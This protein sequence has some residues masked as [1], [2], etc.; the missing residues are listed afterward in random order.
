LVI[1]V[2]PTPELYAYLN[3]INVSIGHMHVYHKHDVIAAISVFR[4]LPSDDE[5][6]ADTLRR[7]CE[8]ADGLDDLLAARF[9]GH[10]LRIGGEPRTVH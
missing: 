10:S 4:M 6:F 1:G 2:Q 9:D 3:D 7:F 8:I 5:V